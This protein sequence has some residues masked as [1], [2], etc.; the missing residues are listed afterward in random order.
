VAT[1]ELEKTK[2]AIAG[3]NLKEALELATVLKARLKSLGVT[4]QEYNDAIFG[5]SPMPGT[6]ETWAEIDR[7]LAAHDAGQK[8]FS[9][10]EMRGFARR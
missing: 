8:G 10:A 2:A 5:P 4:I 1:R 7:D 6:P 3:S 9:L